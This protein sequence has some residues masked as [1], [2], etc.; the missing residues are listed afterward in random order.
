MNGMLDKLLTVA[1]LTAAGC[2]FAQPPQ[3]PPATPF[4]QGYE[5][6]KDKFPAAYNAPAR[7]DV[8]KSWDIFFT[9]SFI[10]WHADQ[11]G[12]DIAFPTNATTGPYSVNT[13]V[14][15]QPFEYKPGFKVGMGVDFDYDN[16]IGNLEYSWF[17]STTATGWKAAPPDSRGTTYLWAL[18]DW[19]YYGATNAYATDLY[20]KWNLKMDLLDATL[21][22]P[23]YQGTKLTILPFGGLR[24]AWMRQMLHIKANEYLI[25]A[26]NPIVSKTL[27]NSWALGPRVGCQCHWLLGWGFRF[28]G[29]VAGSLLYTRYT[30]LA[31][32]EDDPAAAGT[33]LYSADSNDSSVLRPMGDMEIGLGYGTYLNRQTYH[34]DLLA[35]Y[36]FNV[37]WGQN[38]MRELVNAF[39]FG[40]TSEAGDLHLH[41]LTITARLDF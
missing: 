16:W 21:S 30:T 14:L 12:M 15:Q 29:D 31:H 22:R 5:L 4:A 25:A 37:M 18:S 33:I 2:A 9:C 6:G 19:Y 41:G 27:S 38:M 28:E 36:D 35:T 3:T 17:R 26:P 7:I 13:H 40:E 11:E 32:R 1:A 39:V 8:N 24:A 23:F 34:F 20:S 10:Y